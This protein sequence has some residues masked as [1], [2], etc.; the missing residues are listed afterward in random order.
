M[1]LAAGSLPLI[2]GSVTTTLATLLGAHDTQARCY[3]TMQA[4]FQV[5]NYIGAKR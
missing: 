1:T 5:P 4:W 3:L 2:L